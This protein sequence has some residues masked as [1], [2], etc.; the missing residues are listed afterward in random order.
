M[1]THI[2]SAGDE[3]TADNLNNSKANAITS[4]LDADKSASPAV[5]DVYLATDTGILYKCYIAGNW[6]IGQAP[7]QAVDVERNYDNDGKFTGSNDYIKLKEMKLGGDLDKCKVVFYFKTDDDLDEANAKVY[8]NGNAIGVE[9]STKST[10]YVRVSEDFTG[11]KE[12]DL[13]QIY[14]R[15]KN[16]GHYVYICNFRLSYLRIP[17]AIPTTNQDP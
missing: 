17:P 14:G 6:E 2:F 7:F 9:H 16:Q 8:K 3:L 13:I 12:G 15:N 11:F 10:S 5:G 4:G 1:A